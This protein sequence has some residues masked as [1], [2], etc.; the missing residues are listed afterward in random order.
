MFKVYVFIALILVINPMLQKFIRQKYNIVSTHRFFRYVNNTHK[1]LE[2]L[3]IA[4]FF[5]FFI[6][7]WFIDEL[8]LVYLLIAIGS[9]VHLVRAFVEYKYEREKKEYIITL[10]DT[11]IWFVFFVIILVQYN[12]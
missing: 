2:I 7:F 12:F 5:I 3:L 11:G 8:V 4:L 1:W 9:T 10:V 6:T